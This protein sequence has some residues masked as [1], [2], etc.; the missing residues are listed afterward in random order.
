M[1]ETYLRF[2]LFSGTGI[3]IGLFSATKV[4]EKAIVHTLIIR[5]LYKIIHNFVIAN[6]DRLKKSS[7]MNCFFE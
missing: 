6:Y 7:Q 4:T 5:I 3:E 1:L 2:K